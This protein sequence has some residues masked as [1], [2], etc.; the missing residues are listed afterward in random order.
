MTSSIGSQPSAEDTAPPLPSDELFFTVAE[1]AKTLKISDQTVRNWIDAGR[2]P[3]LRIGRRV[4]VPRTAFAHLLAHGLT[5]S[6]KR[7]GSASSR[8]RSRGIQTRGAWL[9]R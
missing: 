9:L 2:L 6:D 8:S 5:L 1:I 7:A 3:A 4:R